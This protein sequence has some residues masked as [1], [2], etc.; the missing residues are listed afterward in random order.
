MYIRFLFNR[1]WYCFEKLDLDIQSSK[2]WIWVL[3]IL[4]FVQNLTYKSIS[5]STLGSLACFNSLTTLSKQFDDQARFS[6]KA[7]L[8]AN[9]VSS[10]YRFDLVLRMLLANRKIYVTNKKV[11]IIISHWKPEMLTTLRSA[12]VRPVLRNVHRLCLHIYRKVLPVY[13][14]DGWQ[15]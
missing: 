5:F 14:F 6:L 1:V 12:I 11:I 13:L 10:L 9:S 4:S 7:S 15:R 2:N 8:I 3:A